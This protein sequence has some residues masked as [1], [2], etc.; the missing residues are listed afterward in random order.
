LKEFLSHRFDAP[1]CFSEELKRT[2]LGALER[3][4]PIKMR[5]VKTGYFNESDLKS[6]KIF[7]LSAGD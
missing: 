5:Y 6:S 4:T 1:R 2:Y 7:H 3:N